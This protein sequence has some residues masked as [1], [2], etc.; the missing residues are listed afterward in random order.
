MSPSVDGIPI[1]NGLLI[2]A[3]SVAVWLG[4]PALLKRLKFL[5]RVGWRPLIIGAVVTTL[6]LWLAQWWLSQRPESIKIVQP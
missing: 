2:S 4:I 1:V 6:L 3:F 5:D